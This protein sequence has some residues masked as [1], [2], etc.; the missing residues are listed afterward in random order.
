MIHYHGIMHEAIQA[1]C[2]VFL[3]SV[4][5][6]SLNHDSVNKAA[7]AV[8]SFFSLEKHYKLFCGRAMTTRLRTQLFFGNKGHLYQEQSHSSQMGLVTA[9][10]LACF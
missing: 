5:L 8:L 6:S 10:K 1:L 9:P 2:N 4:L 7:M 3:E